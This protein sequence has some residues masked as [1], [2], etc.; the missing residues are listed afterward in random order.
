MPF[1]VT[2]AFY[3]CKAML[4]WSPP[5][6]GPLQVKGR[7]IF[8]H[9]RPS[10]NICS[11]VRFRQEKCQGTKLK[12]SRWCCRV[13]NLDISKHVCFSSTRFRISNC[14]TNAAKS[15]LVTMLSPVVPDPK[16][17]S[18]VTARDA[19]R[20]IRIWIG[21][22]LK[23]PYRSSINVDISYSSWGGTCINFSIG[24]DLFAKEI[25]HR[26]PKGKTQ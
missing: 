5:L 17:V 25:L 8:L 11:L 15:R 23:P 3:Q 20:R 16:C 4:K 22:N 19:K 7:S 12:N 1:P 14:L 21:Q 26:Y 18:P 10:S 13:W 6:A 2:T 24:I 9:R